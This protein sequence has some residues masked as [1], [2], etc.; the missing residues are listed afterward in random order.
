NGKEFSYH[1]LIT[2]DTGISI[3]FCYPYHSWE[4]GTN[5]NTN[6]LLR[7]YFPKK[8]VHGKI[9]SSDIK[10]IEDKLNHRPRKRLNYLTPYEVFV[11]KMNPENFQVQ[12]LI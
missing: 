3:Y 1:D 8:A 5:E 12:V 11:K 4:R 2:L 10:L 7:Q 6:G 9:T